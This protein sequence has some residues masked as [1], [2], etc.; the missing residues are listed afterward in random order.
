MSDPIETGGRS[1]ASTILQLEGSSQPS[2]LRR[3]RTTSQSSDERIGGTK[4]TASRRLGARKEA[5]LGPRTSSSRGESSTMQ[6]SN[7]PTQL[8]PEMAAV[9]Y[10]RTGRISKAKKGLKVHNCECGRVSC[11]CPL[12]RSSTFWLS[13]MRLRAGCPFALRSPISLLA[14]NEGLLTVV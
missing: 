3:K 2:T 11:R 1:L 10:T 12:L 14:S 6:R 13:T 4:F 9:N 5:S 7:S 8:S